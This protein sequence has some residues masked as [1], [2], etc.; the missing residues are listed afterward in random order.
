MRTYN[1]ILAFFTFV[2]F[3]TLFAYAASLEVFSSTVV[4]FPLAVGL[5]ALGGILSARWIIGPFPTTLSSCAINYFSRRPIRRHLMIRLVIDYALGQL[6]VAER[7]IPLFIACSGAG[8]LTGALVRGQG[9]VVGAVCVYSSFYA[10]VIIIRAMGAINPGLATVGATVVRH[11]SLAAFAA[12]VLVVR[13]NGVGVLDLVE[14]FV[15]ANSGNSLL[16]GCGVSL[17]ARLPLLLCT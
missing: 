10:A 16:L 17:V 1:N 15:V 12:A 3:T 14:P 8:W 4:D 6:R 7:V 13:I 5:S 9:Q 2:L 11:L